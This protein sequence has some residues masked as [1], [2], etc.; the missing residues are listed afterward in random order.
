MLQLISDI[1]DLSKIEA[2]ILEFVKIELDV[3]ALCSDVVNATKLRANPDVEVI[4]DHHLPECRIVSDCNRLNQVLANFANNATKFT[5]QG[6]IRI[7]YDQV[8]E[9]HLRFYVTDTGVGIAKEMQTRIFERFVKLDSFVQGTGLGLP[10]CSNIIKRL[11][12]SIGVESKL[13]KG[14]TFW[15]T[16]PIQ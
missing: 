1:L 14:S 4:F 13:G 3:N 9:T 15:C 10:I 8:D 16:V 5:K 12:G 7:G 6:S 11:G 2:G